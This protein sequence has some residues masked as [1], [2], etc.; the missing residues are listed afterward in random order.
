M[1]ISSTR[2]RNQAGTTLL[3]VLVGIVIF[4]VGIMALAQLQGNLSK[5]S[6]DSNARTVA[7][8]IAEETIEAAR[9]FVQVTGGPGAN[10]F[11]NIVSGTRT[12]SRGG[13]NYTVASTVTDYYYNPATGSF[14]TSKPNSTIVN[15]DLKR[16]QLAVTWGS[17]QTFQIDEDEVSGD[18]GTGTIVLTD[19]ISSI[20]SPSGGKVVL[21]STTNELYGPPVDYTPGQNPDIV[22]IKLGDNRFKESTTPLPDVIRSD[23]LVETS[24]DVVTYSQSDEGATFLRREEFRAVSCECTLRAATDP[25]DGGLRP[26]IWNGTDYTEGEWVAKPY[27]VSANNQQSD[28]CSICCRDHHDGGTGTQDD[29]NDPGRSLT[30]PFRP[31]SQYWTS[32][33]GQTGLIGDHKHYRRSNN[34]TLTLAT[35]GNTYVEACRL[36]RKDGFFRVAQDLRQEG[37][38]SFPD[39]Y[40]DEDAEI[41]EYSQYVTDAVSIFKDAT[42]NGYE[43]SPPT[44]MQPQDMAEPV[45]FP[46]SQQQNAT[47]M[48]SSRANQQLRNRGIYID[49]MS[50]VL[51][52]IVSCMDDGGSGSECGVEGANSPLEVIPFYDVQLTWLARWTETPNNNPVDVTNEAVRDNNTHSRGFADLTSGYGYSEINA[53]SHRGN[54]GLTATDPI[55]PWY[56]GNLRDYDMYALAATST[57]PPPTSGFDVSG[58]I[59]SAVGGV[60]AADV[61]IEVSEAQCDR[62]SV[63]FECVVPTGANNPRIKVYNYFK[64][65]KILVACSDT[66]VIQG[67]NHSG[68]DPT[69]NWTRFTLPK[70][71][72]SGADIVIKQ[73]SC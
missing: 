5:G 17:G 31:S 67:T 33:D 38:N 16:L 56:A 60:K 2:M 18:I 72:V 39:D 26:T 65:N 42:G 63:G 61:E 34:G 51:R 50:D 27:G 22:S 46:A 52:D 20:T 29:V 8:N 57:P 43:Q 24:F 25:G 36:V 66:L 59:L 54:L 19:M 62:T 70:S 73:D 21:N 41:E 58:S 35:V 44:L 12:E 7:I 47:T 71:D 53:E 69:Q 9:T 68:S 10:A 40:L 14:S 64:R 23:E 15:A 28:F 30:D 37:N 4:A 11:N 49:Y 48:S 45:T 3:E 13:I 55:D 1:N 6:A 32:A